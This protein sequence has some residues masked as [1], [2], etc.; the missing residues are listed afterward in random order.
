[1]EDRKHEIITKMEEKGIS[2][3]K[4]AEAI[5]FDPMILGLYLVKDAYPVPTRILDKLE[6]ALAN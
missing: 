6:T 3:A 5:A 1:M 4:A 2:V